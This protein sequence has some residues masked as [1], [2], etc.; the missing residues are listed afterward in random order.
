MLYYGKAELIYVAMK[1]K[2]DGSPYEATVS[3]TVRVKEVKT[4]SMNYYTTFNANQRSMRLSKNIV[5]PRWV[6]EDIVEDGTRYE[7]TY[8]IINGL[9]YSVKQT[10]IYFKMATTRRILDIQELR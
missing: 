3:R 9:K 4:F 6:C 1:R 8:V 5:V 7:L 10:L 2:E